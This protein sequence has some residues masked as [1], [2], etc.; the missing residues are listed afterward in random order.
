M[1]FRGGF[2]RHQILNLELLLST[3][4][5]YANEYRIRQFSAES[6][7]SDSAR[8]LEFNDHSS[9]A[10][11]VAT[12]A[13][14]ILKTGDRSTAEP[15]NTVI[16]RLQIRNTGTANAQNILITDTLPIRYRSD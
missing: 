15:G 7:R 13:L 12:P 10:F 6:G 1:L 5:D 4:F 2:Q 16:Y 11:C 8:Y 14:E 9:T 3:G